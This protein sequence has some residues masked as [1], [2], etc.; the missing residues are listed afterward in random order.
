LVDL[1]SP[2]RRIYV[3]PDGAVY[4]IGANSVG[5]WRAGEWRA[6]PPAPDINAFTDASAGF[7]NGKLIVYAVASG[8]ILISE[9]AGAT[10]RRSELQLGSQPQMPA[11]ATSLQHPSVAYVSYRVR[12]GPFGVAKTTDTGAPGN[13]F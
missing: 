7:S 9:D 5:T 12:G 4:V 6:G 1:P 8:A 3:D 2:A 11:V 13:W 10:W